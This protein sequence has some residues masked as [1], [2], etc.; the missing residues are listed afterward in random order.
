MTPRRPPAAPGRRVTAAL[1]LVGAALTGCGVVGPTACPAVGWSNVLTV[2][3]ADGWPTGTGRTVQ[4]VCSEPCGVSSFDGRGQDREVDMP[5][6]GT[7]TSFGVVMTI[8]ESVVV[9]VL[10]ASGA[11]L[12]RVEAEPEWVRVGGTEECGG[13]HEATVTVPTP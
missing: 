1:V 13:P 3:L 9:T 10:D 8:P 5:I 7:S 4:L 6:S 11:E 12:A 2:T